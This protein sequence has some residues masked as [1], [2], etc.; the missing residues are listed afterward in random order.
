MTYRG[1]DALIFATP[2]VG[3]VVCTRWPG[4]D[5]NSR[6][7]AAVLEVPNDEVRLD[8]SLVGVLE[9]GVG[10]GNAYVISLLPAAEWAVDERGTLVAVAINRDAR[11]QV[12]A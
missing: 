5:M 1:V 7:P 2:G 3:T 6:K 8:D 11:L 12:M 9:A 4:A 10:L